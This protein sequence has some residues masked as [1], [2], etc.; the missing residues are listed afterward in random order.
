MAEYLS[1]PVPD[2][3]LLEKYWGYTRLRP[4]QEEVINS[5]LR[6]EDTLALMPTGG[7]KTLCYQLP[8]LM[9]D[10]M[11]LVVSPLIAL[12]RE[13]VIR[14]VAQGIAAA[15]LESGMTPPEQEGLLEQARWGRL[16][17]LYVSPERLRGNLFREFLPFLPLNLI[18]VDEA[19]CISQWGYDFRP[20]YLQVLSVRE[21]HPGTPMLALSGSATPLV[22]RDIQE[23][24]AFRKPKLCRSSFLRPNLKFSVSR[25]VD[26][27]KPLLAELSGAGGSALVYCT[28]RRSSAEV[29]ELLNH[30]GIPA[31]CYHAGLSRAE[32]I[33]QQDAWTGNEIRVI[34]CTSAF[35]MGIDKPDV[36]QVI[37][38]GMPESPEEYL[39]QAG[40]GGRDGD[41][42]HALLLVRPDTGQRLERRVRNQFPDMEIIRRVYQGL[43]NYLQ[44]PRGTG[45]GRSFDFQPLEFA[46]IFREPGPLV[47]A[48]LGLLAREEVLEYRELARVP[49]RIL[50]RASRKTIQQIPDRLNYLEPLLDSLQR[51]YEGIRDRWVVIQEKWLAQILEQPESRIRKDLLSLRSAGYL[52]YLPGRQF[53][54]LYFFRDRPATGDLQ[55][56]LQRLGILK[57][58]FSARFRA[59]ID[60]SEDGHCRNQWLMGYFGETIP[61]CGTCDFCLEPHSQAGM[62]DA[63]GASF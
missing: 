35:G 61:P 46:R 47:Q 6:G 7:G 52:G 1:N 38:L 21:L 17:L 39:Q 20:S 45:A 13:Q 30:R 19:H 42:A 49:S 10:G 14:L 33:K 53:P 43:V 48:V 58:A 55:I 63:A 26:L 3:L 4:L 56:D 28:S 25:G 54:Q 9:R 29:A 2:L 11:A 50:V 36:R 41:P 57:S 31:V 22:V 40:R 60:Y 27:L 8:A 32:R 51:T 62:D 44:L 12:M 34:T 15:A 18:A 5:V 37:H 59:M 24:L 23:K 16:K